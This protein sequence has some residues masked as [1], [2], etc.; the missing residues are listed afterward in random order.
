MIGAVKTRDVSCSFNLPVTV[1][2][3]DGKDRSC[4]LV[5]SIA[6]KQV[7]NILIFLGYTQI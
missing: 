6:K 2:F 7:H 1:H 3:S 5:H 4:F